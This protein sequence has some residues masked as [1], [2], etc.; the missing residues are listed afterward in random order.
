MYKRQANNYVKA[1]E[2]LA[3]APNQKVLMLPLEATSLIGSIG[4]IAEIA[5]EALIGRGD[6]AGGDAQTRP[7]PVSPVPPIGPA[8]ST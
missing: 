2:A 4:G 7:R 3:Q 8:R 1:L 5:R 6:G